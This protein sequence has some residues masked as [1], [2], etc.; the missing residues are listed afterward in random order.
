MFEL[1]IYRKS[2]FKNKIRLATIK[3][4]GLG[5]IAWVRLYFTLKQSD[6]W[7]R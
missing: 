6:V 3:T 4:P 2:S 5:F 7:S 1:R